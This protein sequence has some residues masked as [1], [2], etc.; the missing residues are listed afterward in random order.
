M[1]DAVQCHCVSQMLQ[2]LS[3]NSFV[4]QFGNFR[5]LLSPSCVLYT[6]LRVVVSTRGASAVTAAAVSI[7]LGS[8]ILAPDRLSATDQYPNDMSHRLNLLVTSFE[9]VGSKPTNNRSGNCWQKATFTD[10]TANQSS[11]KSSN[12][13]VSQATLRKIE[14]VAD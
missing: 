8:C 12:T 13:T 6:S 9:C 4:H 10:L 1:L 11:G 5:F 14:F 2:A 7:L 3:R